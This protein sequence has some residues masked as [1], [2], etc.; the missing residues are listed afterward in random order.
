M[1]RHTANEGIKVM[2]YRSDVVMAIKFPD[3]EQMVGFISFMKMNSNPAIA[4]V[5]HEMTVAGD[6]VACL[7]CDSIKWYDGYDFVKA[8]EFILEQASDR[9]FGTCFI[10]I[11]EE[12]SDIEYR[13]TDDS[14]VLYDLFEV[15]RDVV[16][17]SD[18][19]PLLPTLT[20]TEE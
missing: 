5:L 19:K 20:K 12:Y 13:I 2:G 6:D 1:V 10:R 4:D 3:R 7:I 18:T 16:F 14:G 8:A 15:R 11:G 17:P 9:D